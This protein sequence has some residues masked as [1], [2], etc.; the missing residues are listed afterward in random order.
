MDR[1]ARAID[2]LWCAALGHHL[3]RWDG[4]EVCTSCGATKRDLMAAHR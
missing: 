1:I 2:R 4:V 3:V